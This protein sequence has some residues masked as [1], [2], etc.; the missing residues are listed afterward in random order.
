MEGQKK[1]NEY[2]HLPDNL[3]NFINTIEQLSKEY[4]ALNETFAGMVFSSGLKAEF[5]K[6][7]ALEYYEEDFRA[8]K[9][10]L[11]QHLE[12]L[13]TSHAHYNR[14]KFFY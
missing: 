13:K 14:E 12:R 11:D 3:G 10:L 1:Y 6:G 4:Q 7:E 8:I 9:T 2:G 5:T